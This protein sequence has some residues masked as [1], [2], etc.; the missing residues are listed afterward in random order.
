MERR[1][2]ALK[3]GHLPHQEWVEHLAGINKPVTIIGENQVKQQGIM[4]GVDE[5]GALLL[6]PEDGPIQ[7]ILAGDVS[8]R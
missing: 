4:I 7:T 3:A 1:Y 8:L 6:Q 2:N 5:N